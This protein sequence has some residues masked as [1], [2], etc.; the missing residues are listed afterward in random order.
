MDNN[1][2]RGPLYH[3]FTCG[4]PATLG[5]SFA[6]GARKLRAAGYGPSPVDDWGGHI[7]Y[8]R[9]ACKCQ[10]VR[11]IR[12]GDCILPI[13]PLGPDGLTGEDIP[14]IRAG[15]EAIA[16]AVPV[17]DRRVEPAV[18]I[19]YSLLAGTMT[20]DDAIQQIRSFGASRSPA[21]SRRPAEVAFS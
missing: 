9:K 17:E 1:I 15:L 3:C 8:L 16:R 12:L 20:P 10:P 7:W 19:V 5:A 2:Q 11:V 6:D 4:A 14:A 21:P 18:R 13:V